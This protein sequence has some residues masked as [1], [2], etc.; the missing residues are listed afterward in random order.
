MS[1]D[2]DYQL[3]FSH[4]SFEYLGE[5]LRYLQTKKE[6][7]DKAKEAGKGSA[8]LMAEL[9]LQNPN[10]VV[11]WGF[12]VTGVTVRVRSWVNENVS[13]LP[14]SGDD[15]ELADL[16][17]KFPE[18]EI[19]GTYQDEYTYGTV[20]SS[21][22]SIEGNREDYDEPEE[23]ETEENGCIELD[24]EMAQSFLED[25]DSVNLA[26]FTSITDAAAEVLSR[27][28]GELGLFRLTELTDAAAEALSNLQGDLCLG[29]LTKLTD[30]A[31][32]A[33]SKHQGGL[34]LSGLTE[35]TEVTADALSKHQGWLD[36]DSVTELTDAAAEAL[37]KHQGEI[38][39]V[40]PA[41]WVA[42]VRAMK[43]LDLAKA[44]Q[45]LVG[46]DFVVLSKMTSITD[47]AAEALSK[48]QGELG[49]SCLT[50]LSDAAAE[51]LSMHKGWLDLSGL[52]EL[53]DA[54]AD[55]LAKHQGGLI[56][57]GLRELSDASAEA[58]AKHQGELKLRGLSE[59]SD[60]GADCFSAHNG[61]IDLNGLIELTPAI[62]IMMSS[63]AM[64]EDD[65]I[66]CD[67]DRVETISPEVAVILG[68]G[69][70]FMLCLDRVSD[71]SPDA[72]RGL[73]EFEGAYL[74]F[75]GFSSLSEELA[76]VLAQAKARTL[77]LGVE[78][79]NDEACEALSTFQG[80]LALE[81]LQT[82]SP[83]GASS[84][85]KQGRCLEFCSLDLESIANGE[86]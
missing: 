49:L 56:L 15:G 46:E 25:P 6:R 7:S 59:L 48:H 14:I 72:A 22:K 71:L 23:D 19:T 1:N 13:N 30:F 65:E 86:K 80:E 33:F 62:A 16:Q 77:S 42:Q 75:N 3:E 68:R 78:E 53:S 35:L 32:E 60:R 64:N 34:E 44:E 79:L 41:D 39:G 52:T 51:A 21:E 73:G 81:R 28:Q 66:S 29:G 12:E 20:S 24:A 8:E 37:C 11:S 47:D 85:L 57:D 43:V 55:A 84:L 31:A 54:A 82:V 9:G 17:R 83:T 18:L 70:Y 76:R 26:D 10:E 50:E 27:C 38:C 40:A 74:G 36:L 45:F 58:L 2:T 69:K 5:V 61:W 4:D 63:K 67:L